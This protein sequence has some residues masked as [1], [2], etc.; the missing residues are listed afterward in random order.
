MESP[1]PGEGRAP[2]EIGLIPGAAEK[3]PPHGIG[4]GLAGEVDLQGGGDGDEVV[5]PPDDAGVVDEIGRPEIEGGV[6]V[7]VVVALSRPHAEGRDGPV[8][9]KV[10]VPVGDHPL[11]E[12]GDELVR[13]HV[14]VKPQVVL[15]VQVFEDGI[16][17]LA[18]SGL[19]G[20][21]VIDQVRDI[22]GDPAGGLDLRDLDGVFQEGLLEGHEAVDILDVDEAVAVGPRHPRVDLGD[23]QGGLADRLPGDVHRYPQAD[24]AEPVRRADLDQGRVQTD[25]APSEQVGDL[26]E[27][28]GD[29]VDLA[30]VCGLPHGHGDEEELELKPPQ[31]G[32]VPEIVLQGEGEHLEEHD[33]LDVG[34]FHHGVNQVPR[35]SAPRTDEDP[36]SV[37][38]P[39]ER[40]I[41]GN[42]FS[43]EGVRKIGH[44]VHMHLHPSKRVA[45]AAGTGTPAPAAEERDPERRRERR[46]LL[47]DEDP[48]GPLYVNIEKIDNRHGGRGT[49]APRKH[50]KGAL[51]TGGRR[52]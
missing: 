51:R 16:G 29:V 42:D 15:V 47:P 12:E 10:L 19:D 23:H 1:P 49:T 45:A 31:K 4:A 50:G 22:A 37:P 20:A 33:I 36:G 21:T 17:H 8:L 18:V 27:V 13:D 28:G 52:G 11:L 35:L 43:P 7:D 48:D 46:S 24:Q 5:V 3:E 25:V 32:F 9:Q 14:G 39:F 44:H 2:D 30:F 38:D 41:R 34:V 26:R 6:V 40:R